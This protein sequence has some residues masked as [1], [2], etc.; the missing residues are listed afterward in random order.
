PGGAQVFHPAPGDLARTR[1][2]RGLDHP[3]ALAF[4]PGG[5]L[6]VPERRGRMRIVGADGKLSP[7]LSGVPKVAASG[8]GGLLDVVLDRRFAENR[9]IYFCYAE[10]AGGGA[11]TAPAR[12]QLV[13]GG[14]PRPDRA[15]GIFPAEGPPPHAHH[16]HCP[17]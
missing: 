11:R 1:G 17:P 8:Q 9:T 5:R 14:S 10:P 12:A 13:D 7:P 4:L 16:F 6:L 15:R 2:A 3:G